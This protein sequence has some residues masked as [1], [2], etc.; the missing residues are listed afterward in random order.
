MQLSA[1]RLAFGN[2]SAET[3][4]DQCGLSKSLTKIP[5]DQAFPAKLPEGLSAP[6]RCDDPTCVEENVEIRCITW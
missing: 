4:E 6:E 3:E 2:V 5:F 1:F